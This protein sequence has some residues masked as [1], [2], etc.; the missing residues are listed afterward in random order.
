MDILA[1]IQ[2]IINL[3]E[4]RILAAL[5]VAN[6]FSGILA[7]FVTSTWNWSEM[8]EVW[9]RIGGVFGAYLVVSVLAY[10]VDGWAIALQVS[11]TVFLS[12]FLVEK[13]LHNLAEMGLPI[14]ASIAELPVVKQIVGLVGV[15]TGLV[16]GLPARFLPKKDET[17]S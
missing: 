6:F 9:K 5:I 12:G 10:Y 2:A 11:I 13:I 7:S 1:F 16:A 17:E 4:V 3:D 14:P 15:G 8:K